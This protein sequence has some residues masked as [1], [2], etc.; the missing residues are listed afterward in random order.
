MSMQSHPSPKPP[1]PPHPQLLPQLLLPQ[2]F[3]LPPPHRHNKIIIHRQELLLPQLL[4]T[5]PLLLPQPQFVADK[6]LMKKSSIMFLCFIVCSAACQGFW[7]F[8][9]FSVMLFTFD[10]FV[11]VR[12]EKI[13]LGKFRPYIA[14]QL[15]I[16]SRYSKIEA[17]WNF[18]WCYP[19]DRS[20]EL[21][22]EKSVACV[23][24]FGRCALHRVLWL[25]QLYV[26]QDRRGQ[27]PACPHQGAAVRHAYREGD[28]GGGGV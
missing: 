27:L 16:L 25:L 13:I 22:H 7:C 3:P 1:K 4:D 2:L 10:S 14:K 18:M 26:L 8:Q 20:S 19:Q 12:P 5:H 15:E 17:Y 23:A 9:K 6:S 11:T 21:T 24:D 28:H